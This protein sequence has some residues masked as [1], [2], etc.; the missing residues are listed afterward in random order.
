M[1]GS[2]WHQQGI[3]LTGLLFAFVLVAFV[4]VVLLRTAPA[5]VSYLTLR[6]AMNSVAQSPEPIVG[7]R[8]AIMDLINRRL[9][10]N[11]VRGIDPKS[12]TIQK[13]DDGTYDVQ[14]AY[15][16]REHLFAN[17]DVVLTFDHAVRVQ[18]Q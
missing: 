15:E 10:I 18:A 14:V 8:P 16:R 12:F 4:A 13:L 7:G 1:S 11:D 5:Y 6:S 3:G 2:R 9:E 17:I